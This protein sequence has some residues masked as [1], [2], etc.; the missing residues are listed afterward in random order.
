LKPTKAALDISKT[1]CSFIS[2]IHSHFYGKSKIDADAHSPHFIYH[3][4]RLDMLITQK[5]DDTELW[6]PK[7]MRIT[8][9]VEAI[10]IQPLSCPKPHGPAVVQL[11]PW[12]PH[13]SAAGCLILVRQ[14]DLK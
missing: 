6:Y 9:D 8:H 1:A 13:N 12:Q 7:R 4:R 2:R 10:Y 11:P 3:G 5:R 14:L